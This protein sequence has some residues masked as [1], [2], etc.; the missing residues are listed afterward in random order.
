MSRYLPK[1]V[2]AIA[3]AACCWGGAVPASADEAR[4]VDAHDSA[5]I[6]IDEIARRLRSWRGS[7]TNIR[8]V[9]E[10]RKLPKTNK[11]LVDSPAPPDAET[12]AL[13]S[14]TEWIWANN[15]LELF[16]ER[17]SFYHDG[18]SASHSIEAYNGP[19]G[20]A[21]VASFR[22]PGPRVAEE[23][24]TL[25]IEDVFERTQTSIKP[26]APLKPHYWVDHAMRLPELLSKSSWELQQ[27][28][29]IAGDPC[30]RIA[31]IPGVTGEPGVY[32][33]LSLDLNHDC[34]VRRDHRPGMNSIAAGDDDFI[35]DEFQRL[36]SGVWFPKRGRSQLGGPS[37]ENRLFLVT[38]A[39]VNEPLDE[40]RFEP[41]APTAGTA[42]DD[43]GR[44]YVHGTPRGQARQRANTKT[45]NDA[46]SASF[47][48][49]LASNW[50]WWSAVGAGA[51]VVLLAAGARLLPRVRAK[52]H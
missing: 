26:H 39:A 23:F 2:S 33:V 24:I 49:T 3:F 14:R 44:S 47:F 29:N 13:I 38:E 18:E 35:I 32:L 9:W 7:F 30:A 48:G 4:E 21:F 51:F 25:R 15:G 6:D 28:E 27:I 42:V 37:G 43:R 1:W 45:A 22:Q 41:P 34:L 50:R 52:H 31:P 11:S 10:T 20:V 46:A 5:N 12:G 19:R 17:S 36:D 16:D 40:A 8:I